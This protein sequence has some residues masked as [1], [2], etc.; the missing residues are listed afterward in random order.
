VDKN[1]AAPGEE[2][3]YTIIYSNIG[4]AN[5][6]AVIILETIPDNTTYVTS[7]AAG[8]GI[9]ILYSHDDGSNYDTS[10]TPPVTNLQFQR[11]AALTPGESGSVTFKVIID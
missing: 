3:T 1:N 2:L 7:S 10:E 6:T 8:S 5:A 4:D 9:T 11:A